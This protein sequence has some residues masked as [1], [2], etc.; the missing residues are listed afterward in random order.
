MDWTIG[1]LDLWTFFFGL[2][3]RP[4][5]GL[6]FGLFLKG[7]VGSLVRGWWVSEF[8]QLNYR[9]Q[10]SSKRTLV[11]LHILTHLKAMVKVRIEKYITP[12]AS[13]HSQQKQGIF[14]PLQGYKHTTR[15]LCQAAECLT[16]TLIRFELRQQLQT[17]RIYLEIPATCTD[18]INMEDRNHGLA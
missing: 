1:P 17:Q 12:L 16:F 8:C 3:F 14:D 7:W 5:L 13:Y 2:F 11:L 9:I 18:E 6:N 15:S 10:Y 4:F